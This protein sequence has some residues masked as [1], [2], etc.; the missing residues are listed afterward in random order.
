MTNVSFEAI[1]KR[2]NTM[3]RTR[4]ATRIT[5][6]LA[7]SAA[8]VTVGV[9]P[10]FASPTTKSPT[11]DSTW[12][13]SVAS[14]HPNASINSELA[15][16]VDQAGAGEWVGGDSNYIVKLPDD[17]LVG[18]YSDTF[19]GPV[20]PDGSIAPDGNFIHNSMLV[21]D[22]ESLETIQGGTAEA[23]AS[24]IEPE[25]EDNWYWQNA[26]QVNGDELQVINLEF[27]QT[28]TTGIFDFEFVRNVIARYDV[29]DLSLIDLT[30]LPSSIPNLEWNAWLQQEGGYTYIYGVRDG[31]SLGQPKY[32]RIARVVGTDLLGTWEYF[33]GSGW[34]T[35]ETSGAD[36][37]PGV[38]NN[39][40]VSKIGGVYVLV[41]QDTT[42]IFSRKV[43]M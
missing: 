21:W 22:G 40:S 33:T 34:S 9:A 19:T 4:R 12:Y 1:E 38:G 35:S 28:G 16:Y 31:S 42:E 39:F 3:N 13:P 15:D 26:A 25:D 17:R 24:I 43:V 23:P 30:E 10:A 36:L 14:A 5:A 6:I 11:C 37:L 7:G 2:R 29:D 8:L 20:N 41:T 27:H 18:L 32:L